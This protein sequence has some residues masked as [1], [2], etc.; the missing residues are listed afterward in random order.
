VSKSNI[1]VLV[2]IKTAEGKYTDDEAKFVDE[3]AGPYALVTSTD[4]L[5]LALQKWDSVY[6]AQMP[7]WY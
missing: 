1:P 2:E 4:E 7:D 5:L 6:L 3:F